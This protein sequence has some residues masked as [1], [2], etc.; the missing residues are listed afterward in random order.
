LVSKTDETTDWA[1]RNIEDVL[2]ALKTNSETGLTSGEAESRL[3][4]YGE[5]VLV[6][7]EKESFL[8]ALKEEVR[9]P[10][11]LLLIIVGVLYSILGSDHLLDAL[12]I[13]TVIIVLVTVEVYNEYK[14]EQGVESLKKLTSP[15]SVC[16]AT[17]S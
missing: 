11:I 8:D 5:N 13:F 7:E 17:G 9:E 16:F 4:R 1:S 14:A 2:K 3:W 15:I 6:A 10:M 12:T